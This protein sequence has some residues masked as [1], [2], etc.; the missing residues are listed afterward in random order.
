M[1][2]LNLIPAPV[3]GYPKYFVLSRLSGWD[4]Y[5]FLYFSYV[6]HIRFALTEGPDR[7]YGLLSV[8]FGGYRRPFPRVNRLELE[9]DQ[10]RPS[11]FEVKVSGT[12]PTLSHTHSWPAKRR[13]LCRY[14]CSN[15]GSTIYEVLTAMAMKITVVWDVICDVVDTSCRRFGRACCLHLCRGYVAPKRCHHQPYARIDIADSLPYV[16][17][18]PMN[19]SVSVCSYWEYQARRCCSK[20]ALL[21]LLRG[22]YISAWILNQCTLRNGI[23]LGHRCRSLQRLSGKK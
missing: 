20:G 14:G 1:S 11:S 19:A 18:D 15:W 22:G 7:L 17:H 23:Y 3:T 21:M 5:R 16:L 10:S 8:L 6:L 12:I 4:I 2:I 13:L 9:V